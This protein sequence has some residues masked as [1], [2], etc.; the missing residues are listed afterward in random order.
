MPFS[1]DWMTLVLLLLFGVLF[2]INIV[3]SAKFK[4]II[5]SLFKIS[6]LEQEIDDNYQFINGFQ[7]LFSFFS[8]VVLSLVFFDIKVVYFGVNW[9]I[10]E[11]F[12]KVFL[13]LLGYFLLKNLVEFVLV[14]LFFLKRK[15]TYFMISKTNYFFAISVCIFFVLLLKQYAHLNPVFIYYFAG[16]LFLVSFIIYLINNKNLILNHLF[17]F[18]LYICALEIAPLLIVF[19]LMF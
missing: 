14:Y 16:F 15:I 8:V 11:G 12:F 4:E 7:L 1:N 9:S 3:D 13:G 18:I 17:Y 19:K 6:F 2:L 5:F 10:F